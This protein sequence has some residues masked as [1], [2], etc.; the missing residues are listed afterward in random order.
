MSYSAKFASCLYGPFRD[1]AHSKPA[2]GN[3][4][5]YQLPVGS[6]SL[7]ILAIERDIQEGADMIMVKPAFPDIISKARDMTDLPI[8]CY[9]VSGEY[10]MLWHAAEAGC[11]SLKEGVMESITGLRR[12]GSDIIITYY[13][14]RILDWI[15]E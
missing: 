2:F 13:T 6:P 11:F 14:P 8:S 4:Q 10:A 9:Q 3:R 7:P 15:K 1:A 5:T 12:A